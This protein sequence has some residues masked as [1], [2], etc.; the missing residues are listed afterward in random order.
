MK[1]LTFLILFLGLPLLAFA[2][3]T[4]GAVNTDT[5]FVPLTNIPQLTEIGG[6]FSL[7]AFLNALY[8]ISI[9]IAAVV[10]VLQ[11]MRAGIMYMGS[12]S[13]FAEKK[14][15]KNLI[16]LS[17]GGL[18]LVLSPVVVF[19]VINPEIL[20]LKIGNIEKLRSATSTASVVSAEVAANTLSVYTGPDRAGAKVRCETAGGTA[21]FTCTPKTG[22]TGRTVPQNEPCAS[23]EDDH[24]VCR[25]PAGG[26]SAS[27]TTTYLQ[28]S[29][30]SG[31]ICDGN[32]GF[33]QIGST[34]C[35]T[36]AQGAVCCGSNDPRAVAV[37]T[38]VSVT[39]YGYIPLAG[40]SE[41]LGPTPGSKAAFD[42]YV[43]LCT[44]AEKQIKNDYGTKRR[45]SEADLAAF[46][47]REGV[48][49]YLW[50][51]TTAVSCIPK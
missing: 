14:E 5:G 21:S 46:P 27:C 6:A 2:Q 1:Y 32:R 45:C 26:I 15:A 8:R 20:T 28:K 29:A 23:S 35:G 19:S 42:Q 30:A 13:G 43:A 37:P 39:K 24:T 4:T 41:D 11:I 48:K 7:E 34:C 3:A 25:A 40:E 17:I 50:C 31:G 18:I 36:L 38:S 51:V 22:G 33:V 10:A 49:P 12:D 47:G 9:G 44:R 16:A